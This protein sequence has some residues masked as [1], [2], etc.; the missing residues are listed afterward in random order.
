MQVCRRLPAFYVGGSSNRGRRQG[1]KLQSTRVRVCHCCLS[2][3]RTNHFGIATF[4]NKGT[5]ANAIHS[6]SEFSAA[7]PSTN[8]RAFVHSGRHISLMIML[9]PI[10]PNKYAYCLLSCFTILSIRVLYVYTCAL[11]CIYSKGVV[12]YKAFTSITH[13]SIQA[14]CPSNDRETLRLE[15]HAKSK[16]QSVSK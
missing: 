6:P 11:L 7:A 14:A 10:P 16:R 15:F 12:I 4:S 3:S 13:D 8:V 9:P 1:T 2:H 5:P